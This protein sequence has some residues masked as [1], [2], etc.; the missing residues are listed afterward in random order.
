M[1]C[2]TTLAFYS[3]PDPMISTYITFLQPYFQGITTN[4]IAFVC[5]LH[6]HLIRRSTYV[7]S[8]K[9]AIKTSWFLYGGIS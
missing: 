7:Y 2:T 9:Y 6:E 5:S 4:I 1:I 3:N 8:C